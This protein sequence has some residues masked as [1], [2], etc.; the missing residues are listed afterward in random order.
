MGYI[1][2]S[3]VEETIRNVFRQKEVATFWDIVQAGFPLTERLSYSDEIAFQNQDD[4]KRLYQYELAL[5]TCL[6]SYHYA[7]LIYPVRWREALDTHLEI[8]SNSNCSVTES[9]G[10]IPFFSNAQVKAAFKAWNGWEIPPD[11]FAGAICRATNG[12]NRTS[13]PWFEQPEKFLNKASINACITVIN[14]YV[15]PMEDANE[16]AR[17]GEWIASKMLFDAPHFGGFDL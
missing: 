9:R 12:W 17:P 2:T 8:V 3:P 10:K 16:V 14:F 15:L 7:G 13:P 5:D 6:R 1:R 4:E 11:E